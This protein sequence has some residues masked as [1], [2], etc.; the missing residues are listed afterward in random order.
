MLIKIGSKPSDATFNES[1]IFAQASSF[2][3]IAV[4][5]VW[6][7]I[8]QF[9]LML[10][11]QLI[12]VVYAIRDSFSGSGPSLQVALFIF[13]PNTFKKFKIVWD[14]IPNAWSKYFA[15]SSNSPYLSSLFPVVWFWFFVYFLCLKMFFSNSFLYIKFSFMLRFVLQYFDDFAKLSLSPNLT[16]LGWV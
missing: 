9:S 8:V 6:V 4:F 12:S 11:L 14:T 7:S 1:K 16:R 3:C 5:I 15:A 2:S 10:L 13:P